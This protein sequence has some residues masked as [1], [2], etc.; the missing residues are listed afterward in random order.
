MKKIIS[1]VSIIIV[2]IGCLSINVNAID[3]NQEI[4]TDNFTEL[5]LAIVINL[6]FVSQDEEWTN[7][8]EVNHL[9]ELYD[10]NDTLSYYYVGVQGGGYMIV[11]A[12][13]N[14]PVV[15]EFSYTGNIPYEKDI[16]LSDKLYYFYPSMI[17]LKDGNSETFS[18]S[19]G[20]DSLTFNKESAINMS[21]VLK[22]EVDNTDFSKKVE[23]VEAVKNS[24]R[25]ENSNTYDSPN[26]SNILLLNSSEYD[27]TRSTLL[28]GSAEIIA[29]AD[30]PSTSYSYLDLIDIDLV[31]DWGYTSEFTSLPDVSN[32][33]AAVAA[34]NTL[35]YYRAF[36]SDSIDSQDRDDV[37][38]DL[39]EYM[40]NGP[41][42]P[43]QY[44][45]RFTDYIESETSYD[46]TTNSVSKTWSVYKGQIAQNR[47]IYLTIWLTPFKAHTFCG[48]GY[49][50]YGTG[51][52]YVH[53]ADGSNPTNDRFYL[54]GTS[55]YA[56]GVVEL[57]PSGC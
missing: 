34:F 38:L 50:E 15:I 46:I 24:I 1:I 39:H 51:E 7:E 6:F 16:Q 26:Q 48:I 33:C 40:D 22:N 54:F 8:T 52:N 41:V 11:N 57:S 55:L 20:Y 37:F 19:L 44:R 35:L 18:T 25:S 2:S 47:M 9:I 17:A 13:L 45:S 29:E 3:S 23:L 12:D 10:A 14:C 32:H 5:D 49:R 43:T 28:G 42:T 27:E 56:M 30:L 53:A 36:Y 4:I 31:D 21:E